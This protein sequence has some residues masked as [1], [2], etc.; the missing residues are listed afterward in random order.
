M[1]TELNTRRHRRALTVFLVI[2]LVHWAERL[3]QAAQLYLLH[4]PA[5]YAR[6]LLGLPFPWLVHPE[7][8]D[9]GYA[10]IMLIGLLVLLPGFTGHA[11]TWWLLALGI[12]SWH[13]FEY[14]LLVPRGEF[15]LFYN[16]VA[17]APVVVAMLLHRRPLRAEPREVRCTCA[18]RTEAAV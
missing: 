1:L 13:H 16:A 12:Q 10:L 9:R 5:P 17:F 4:L 6:G 8:M 18:D 14:L 3:L 7:R 2:L 15:H 11:R